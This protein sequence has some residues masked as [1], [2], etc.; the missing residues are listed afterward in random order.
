LSRSGSECISLPPFTPLPS[1]IISLAFLRGVAFLS[2]P[3]P[4]NF[5]HEENLSILQLIP[6]KAALSTLSDAL[7]S[8]E[9]TRE[10]ISNVLTVVERATSLGSKL[11][12]VGSTF[13]LINDI[14]NHGQEGMDEAEDAAAIVRRVVDVLQ[15]LLELGKLAKKSPE[16]WKSL[17]K[18]KIDELRPV[19]EDTLEVVRTFGKRGWVTKLIELRKHGKSI[20]KL[21]R[22]IEAC[23]ESIK[24][25]VH[26]MQTDM[27]LQQTEFTMKAIN[28]M[29][30]KFG[31]AIQN[32]IDKRMKDASAVKEISEETACE[33][34]LQDGVAM[35]DVAKKSC[36]TDE[37]FKKEMTEINAK[38]D[39]LKKG[40]GKLKEGQAEIIHLLK[41]GHAEIIHLYI[42]LQKPPVLSGHFQQQLEMEEKLDTAMAKLKAKKRTADMSVRVN[43]AEDKIG[44]LD[45][46]D[47][48]SVQALVWLARG[49]KVDDPASKASPRVLTLDVLRGR[50]SGLDEQQRPKVVFVMMQYGA[51]E[52]ARSLHKEGK[53]PLVVWIKGDEKHLETVL[54][55]I[56]DSIVKVLMCSNIEPHDIENVLQEH[57]LNTVGHW[58]KPLGSIQRSN[59]REEG[60]MTV[61]DLF[62]TSSSMSKNNIVE[63]NRNLT[64]DLQ[65]LNL[66]AYDLKY[67]PNLQAQLQLQFLED[68]K[69]I[70]VSLE[71]SVADDDLTRCRALAL[72]VCASFVGPSNFNCIYRL[73]NQ[74]QLLQI[75][76]DSKRS[77]TFHRHNTLLWIDV[78]DDVKA[79]ATLFNS[80]KEEFDDEDEHVATLLTGKGKVFEEWF[81]LFDEDEQ[82]EK[83]PV[84]MESTDSTIQCSDMY[85]EMVR[86]QVYKNGEPEADPLPFVNKILERIQMVGK[87][88]ANSIPPLLRGENLLALYIDDASVEGTSR[89][90]EVVIR[91]AV[92]KVSF[93]HEFSDEMMRGAFDKSVSEFVQ[94]GE[95][96][97]EYAIH[98]DLTTFAEKYEENLKRLDKFTPH[99]LEKLEECKN[100]PRIFL[101]APAGAGKTFLAIQR[102]IEMLQSEKN[103]H[104]LLIVRNAPLALTIFGW[105]HGLLKTRRHK[106]ALKTRFLAC[107]EPF[108]EGLHSFNTDESERI[109]KLERHIAEDPRLLLTVVDEAHHIYKSSAMA[110]ALHKYTSKS[111]ELWL[112]ADISQSLGQKIKYPD[113][114]K[115]KEVTLTEVVRCTPRIMAAASVSLGSGKGGWGRG[116]TKSHRSVQAN[117]IL[118]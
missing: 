97:A 116:G 61:K 46:L 87:A 101:R 15:Y 42:V 57:K 73:R 4:P 45:D 111:D 33:E 18:S 68:K 50:L 115:M 23:M 19:L 95:T 29:E 49:Y 54:G 64:K 60:V 25:A 40:Q 82:C 31:A 62:T 98:S 86:F 71:A 85:D 94:K 114:E 100:K 52:A 55:N 118:P 56:V 35:E 16:K 112:L 75:S 77:E 89:R 32:E 105:V 107:F 24:G 28:E 69:N 27:Q 108:G 70:C 39:E 81:D 53:V 78:P 65:K 20:L 26:L 83:D 21:S 51:R 106:K 3:L 90:C 102:I 36:L 12:F 13:E 47:R 91:H 113:E 92:S 80:V 59:S 58:G 34:V 9:K 76:N 41:G 6:G 1:P 8:N 110:K 37:A 7:D 74:D 84:K 2:V 104:T 72:E 67:I 79:A 117:H 63:K 44:V 30:F 5:T 88:E 66:Q 99:Q 14:V 10:T 103:G 17:I 96:S 11:P 109:I 38:L 48:G 93:L 22:S 43:T